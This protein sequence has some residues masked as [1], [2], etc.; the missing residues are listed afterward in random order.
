MLLKRYN[1]VRKRQETS[2][3][4]PFHTINELTLRAA[5]IVGE[6][7]VSQRRSER[8]HSL[9]SVSLQLYNVVFYVS[10]NENQ[11]NKLHCESTLG[12]HCCLYTANPS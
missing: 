4:V 7:S 1:K 8:G 3:H 9:E 12:V 5:L 2:I 10:Q 6:Q 11:P